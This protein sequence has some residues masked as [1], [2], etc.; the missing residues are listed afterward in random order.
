MTHKASLIVLDN[1][2]ATKMR[3]RKMIKEELP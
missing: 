1:M 3:I 2:V